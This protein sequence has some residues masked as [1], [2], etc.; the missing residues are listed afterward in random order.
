VEHYNLDAIIAVGYRVNSKKTTQFRIRA[1]H[2][3][4]EYIIKGFAMDDEWLKQVDK[5]DY[6]DEWLERIQ[7]IRA[8]VFGHDLR[9]IPRQSNCLLDRNQ[10]NYCQ[11]SRSILL[12]LEFLSFLTQSHKPSVFSCQ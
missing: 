12:L 9:N 7:E 6:F 2:I 11:I 1:T 10:V 8:S 4:K 3:L 5:W